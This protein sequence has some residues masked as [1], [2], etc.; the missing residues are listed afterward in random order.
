[1]DPIIDDIEGIGQLGIGEV[2]K[3]VMAARLTPYNPR[4]RQISY[5][6]PQKWMN[7]EIRVASWV[8]PALF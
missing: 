3:T 7:R 6:L 4:G 5:R 1:M 8:L 2:W